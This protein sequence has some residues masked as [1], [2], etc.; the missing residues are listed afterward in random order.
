MIDYTPFLKLK[1]NEVAGL[2]ALVPAVKSALIPFFD[3]PQKPTLTAASFERMVTKGAASVARHLD[4]VPAFFLDNFDI[5]DSIVVGGK[6]NYVFVMEA[7]Q[8]LPFI[9]VIGLDRAPGRNDVVFAAKKAGV[10]SSSAFALRLQSDDFSS[11][12][13]IAAEL[14][15]LLEEALTHFDK[16][17][18]ILDNR[19][20]LNLDPA[21]RA[22]ELSQFI[23]DFSSKNVADRIIVVGS[24][25]PPSIGQIVGV[26]S[27]L[28]QERVEL[29]IFHAVRKAVGDGVGIGDYTI[30][31][32]L[33]SDV[34]IPP[35][36]MLNVM[37]P[38]VIYSYDKVHFVVRGGALRTHP[39][40]NLQYNDIAASL[41]TKPF[42]RGPG[43]S[44]GD[45][46]ISDK[47]NMI[48]NQ[49]TPGSILKPTI[50]A[51]IT[52]MAQTFG[53]P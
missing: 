23:K 1:V 47:A 22:I 27:E 44:F 21:K 7:F 38:R 30:V 5:D 50:N 46:F 52:Y 4:D 13:V 43:Y 16:S 24:S 42:Y 9:P 31:S 18:L 40:G 26:Q 53:L 17:T 35:A 29:Q 36:V 15:E 48:G 33:Y 12:G 25:I 49:V 11:Y 19:V 37:A 34:D 45:G 8:D 3:L 14:E 32:P 2:S 39:R 20:C 41:L 10:V 28:V 6:D 51:H